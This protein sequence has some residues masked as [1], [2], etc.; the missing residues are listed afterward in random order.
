MC[1]P[2]LFGSNG[3]K[4]GIVHQLASLTRCAVKSYLASLKPS[5]AIKIDPII[6]RNTFRLAPCR[7]VMPGR[8]SLCRNDS[9]I[10]TSKSHI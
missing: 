2:A 1:W 4:G 10:R 6:N 8:G 5:I 3:K 7:Y 9:E